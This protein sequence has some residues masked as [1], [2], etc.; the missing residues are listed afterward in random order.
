MKKFYNGLFFINN[1]ILIGFFKSTILIGYLLNLVRAN[2]IFCKQFLSTKGFLIIASILLE[3]SSHSSLSWSFDLLNEFVEFTRYLLRELNQLD[4]SGLGLS[5]KTQF[6]RH[7]WLNLLRQLFGHIL[8]NIRLWSNAPIEVR[9]CL[10]F[11]ILFVW[12]FYNW[13]SKD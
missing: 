3:K 12:L 5:T 13:F 4:A 7:A 6:Y 9:S 2:P 8:T 1:R 11:S 10:F